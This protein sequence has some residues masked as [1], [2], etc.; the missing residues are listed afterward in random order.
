MKT[1]E[2]LAIGDELLSGE[3][4]D[5]NSSYL[6]GLLESWGYTVLRHVTVP[7]DEVA[8]AA[9]YKEAAARAE[10]VLS[11]GGLGPTDDDLTLAALA[12][13]LGC[14]LVRHEPTLDK[15]KAMFAS[16]GREMT[17]NNERQAMVPKLGEVL[18]NQSGTAPGFRA[19]LGGAQIFLMPGVPREVR[20][21][22]AN[23]IEAWIPKAG[24]LPLR[25]TI[26]VM[27]VGESKLEHEIRAVVK[28]HTEVRFGYR[29]LGFENHVK[30]LA[31][32]E[33]AAHRLESV[34]VDLA[35]VLGSRIYGR[36]QDD[37]A[38]V[39]VKRL[40]AR[41]E[42]VAVAESCTGGWVQRLITDVPG[43][44]ACFLGGT[45]TY[46]NSAKTTLID[47][48]PGLLEAHG[49]VSHSVAKAMAD[50]VRRRLGSTWAISTTGVA[51]PDGGTP[52][53]PVG[54]VWIG[55][56]G[57]DDTSAHRITF[58]GDRE[59]VRGY[60]AKAALDALRRQ[61]L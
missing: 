28:K 35:A 59:Q 49:A 27:G 40:M 31:S 54:T 22:M 61:L 39:V 18:D 60:S 48:D 56:A 57:P 29:T 1:A 17:P 53:K 10:V 5:T 20:W 36:D 25:R 6:D 50:G 8:I 9:A 7:D 24:D 2:V 15:I 21:L 11:T 47:V 58:P 30:L 34:E 43:C 4:V 46:A 26:K 23:R 41:N 37:L 55:V 38:T 45:V 14:E 13:A 19:R 44:S 51:G 3:T 12:K 52:D 33:G 16:F 42:T 32:G